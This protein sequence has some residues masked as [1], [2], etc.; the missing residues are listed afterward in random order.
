MRA[1]GQIGAAK[2]RFDHNTLQANSKHTSHTNASGET[3]EETGDLSVVFL[4][5]SS[6]DQQQLFELYHFLHLKVGQLFR[7]ILTDHPDLSLTVLNLA[8][9]LEYEQKKKQ[10]EQQNEQ[11]QHQTE[12][13]STKSKGTL[14]PN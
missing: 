7:Q 6:V 2:V 14:D 13:A 5:C 12:K 11:V 8:L 1:V 9:R 4:L 3:N 10:T